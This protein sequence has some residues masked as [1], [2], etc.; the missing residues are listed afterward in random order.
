MHATR[1]LNEL[2]AAWLDLTKDQPPP[3][4]L[5]FEQALQ[6]AKELRRRLRDGNPL[7]LADLDLDEDSKDVLFALVGLVCDQGPEG[8]ESSN[9]RATEAARLHHFIEQT[10]W[11]SDEFGQ[12]DELLAACRQTAGDALGEIPGGPQPATASTS[13]SISADEEAKRTFEDA[14]AA[15]RLTLRSAYRM[16]QPQADEAE[17]ALLTWLERY[18]RRAGTAANLRHVLFAACSQLAPK[19]ASSRPSE[20]KPKNLLEFEGDQ[21]SESRKNP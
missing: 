15:I 2:I 10:R 14:R 16:T 11:E 3:P 1:P 8:D 19:L 4:C 7:P 5:P 21:D 20:K 6:R 13:T 12:K 18:C 9:T 17:R